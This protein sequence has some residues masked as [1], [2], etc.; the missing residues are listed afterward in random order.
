MQGQA[1]HS[2]W[3]HKGLARSRSGRAQQPHTRPPPATALSGSP[4]AP[5]HSLFLQMP[6]SFL[7]RVAPQSQE[8]SLEAPVA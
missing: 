5:T 1:W 6:W 8:D 2:T 4:D 7:A 3:S